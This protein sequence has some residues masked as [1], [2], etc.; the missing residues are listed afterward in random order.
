MK[1][2]NY[3]FAPLDVGDGVDLSNNDYDDDDDDDDDAGTSTWLKA[4]PQL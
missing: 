2:E 1:K 4:S 3:F